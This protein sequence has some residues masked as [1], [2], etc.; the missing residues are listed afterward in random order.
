MDPGDSAVRARDQ[1]RR[2]RLELRRRVCACHLRVQG[3]SDDAPRDGIDGATLFFVNAGPRFRARRTEP[4]AGKQLTKFPLEFADVLHGSRV[5]EV[6]A[7][8]GSLLTKDGRCA[9]VPAWFRP[10][11]LG[12]FDSRPSFTSLAHRFPFPKG[13]E[14]RKQI[15]FT[16]G[17]RP[18]GRISLFSAGKRN[19]HKARCQGERGR[20]SRGRNAEEQIGA[21]RGPPTR[22]G[23]L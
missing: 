22:K 19:L 13:V 1:R 16:E 11:C 17:E 5:E 2:R 20:M 21:S 12:T 15:G 9:T 7:A 4:H 18:S 10:R 14:C 23:V 6:L 8:K 3:G